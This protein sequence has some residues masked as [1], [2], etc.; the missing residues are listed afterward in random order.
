MDIPNYATEQ[1]LLDDVARARLDLEVKWIGR[2]E[3]SHPITAIVRDPVTDRLY[4]WPGLHAWRGP[5]PDQIEVPRAVVVP[6]APSNRTI[7]TE[8]FKPK[9]LSLF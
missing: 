3:A 2:R 5:L 4:R 7:Q 1:E 6:G 8:L 9:Q